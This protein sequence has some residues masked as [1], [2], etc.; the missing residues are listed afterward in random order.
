MSQPWMVD[1]AGWDDLVT[2]DEPG[3]PLSR[4]TAVDLALA[5]NRA[6]FHFGTE[7]LDDE[8]ASLVWAT[9]MPRTDG[10]RSP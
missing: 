3:R 2:E 7:S 6:S 10:V 9:P 1:V 8:N 4:R 5:I